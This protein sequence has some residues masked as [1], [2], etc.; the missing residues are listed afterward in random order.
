MCRWYSSYCIL[1]LFHGCCSVL[2]I[3]AWHVLK[4]VR[5]GRLWGVRPWSLVGEP[6]VLVVE[7]ALTAVTSIPTLADTFTS[8]IRSI[9]YSEH[10]LA[11]SLF[12]CSY[13]CC[14]YLW[15]WEP[16]VRHSLHA[17]TCGCPPAGRRLRSA[18]IFITCT[19][20]GKPIFSILPHPMFTQPFA[21]TFLD[22]TPLTT[23]SSRF[24]L[25]ASIDQHSI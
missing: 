16:V 24:S 14:W 2:S 21:L 5:D 23:A 8:Y 1:F 15:T 20:E 12:T 6:A 18:A 3:L 19:S 17:V 9:A 4:H 10:P 22:T 25:L 13:C 7:R 11:P